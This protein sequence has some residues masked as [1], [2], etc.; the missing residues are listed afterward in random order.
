[1]QC[2][3]ARKNSELRVISV[4]DLLNVKDEGERIID[5]PPRF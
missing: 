5:F 4:N 1:M 2:I 3:H